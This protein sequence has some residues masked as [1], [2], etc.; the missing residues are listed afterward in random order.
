MG[1]APRGQRDRRHRQDPSEI[2]PISHGRSVAAWLRQNQP[3]DAFLVGS[4][5]A[6]VSTV[7][8]YL[9]RPI[10]YLECECDRT[11]VVWNTRRMS[12]LSPA[13]LGERLARAIDGS[14]RNEAILILS[15]ELPPEAEAAVAPR[16]SF[17]PERRFQERASTLE[18]YIVYRVTVHPRCGN[19]GRRSQ[20]M[21]GIF[22]TLT[23]LA[24]SAR[25]PL[26]RNSP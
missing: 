5:D 6:Q 23:F 11:F 24:F 19:R 2:D 7:A 3:P 9:G 18:K 14:G 17:T 26:E 22:Y 1:G 15:R 12:R 20:A 21:I 13:E 10:Y 16:L 25:S 8:G 4:R